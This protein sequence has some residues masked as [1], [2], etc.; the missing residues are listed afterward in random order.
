MHP[1]KMFALLMLVACSGKDSDT[2]PS[3]DDTAPPDCEAIAVEADPADGA[4]D[5]YYRGSV[6]FTLDAA[7][8]TAVVSVE[9]PDGAV[10]G[11]SAW[12]DAQSVVWTPSAPLA[13]DTS[14]TATLAYACGEESATW[15]TSSTGTP[16]VE[17]D[18]VGGSWLLDFGSGVFTEPG[19]IGDVV[20]SNLRVDMLL[21][22]VDISG[23]TV[24]IRGAPAAE[25]GSGQDACAPSLEF[26][27][28]ADFSANPY[29]SAGTEEAT[30]TA[31][32]FSMTLRGMTL[33][34]DF[35]PDGQEVQGIALVGE[36]VEDEVE[37][38]VCPF[39]DAL[40]VPCYP[41]D[42]LEGYLCLPIAAE[43]LVATRVEG[44]TLETITEGDVRSNEACED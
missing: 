43:Q 5:V 17:A 9:G 37:G 35:A 6:T 24:T 13:P 30:I 12:A 15:T 1:G 25:D 20:Q 11:A 34:G 29:F 33:S 27:E 2:G 36:M 14:Y 41:C 31:Q 22:V 3:G 4:D 26:P 16:V 39:V 42:G 38:L 8:D 23:D 21:G 10:D 32:G 28:P 40:G 7:D 19:D 44:V 18:I